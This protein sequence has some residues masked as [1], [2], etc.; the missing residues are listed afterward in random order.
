MDSMSR[1]PCRALNWTMAR[2]G[3]WLFHFSGCRPGLYAPK[4]GTDFLKLFYY[5]ALSACDH[6][7]CLIRICT[8]MAH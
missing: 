7:K 8:L 2:G 1:S 3:D 5:E 4:E 6:R